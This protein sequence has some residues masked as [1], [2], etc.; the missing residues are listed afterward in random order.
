M[1]TDTHL[2]PPTTLVQWI[3][4]HIEEYKLSSNDERPMW[5]QVV[6]TASLIVRARRSDEVT[7]DLLDALEDVLDKFTDGRPEMDRSTMDEMAARLRAA[8][9]KAKGQ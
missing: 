3:E 1:T 4:N 7:A 5:L 8:I 9:N 6:P 2:M